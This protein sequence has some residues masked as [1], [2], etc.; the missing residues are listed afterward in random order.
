MN[1]TLGSITT[2]PGVVRGAVVPREVL[3]LTVLIDHDVVDGAVVARFFTRLNELVG[4]GC[5]L[6]V[7]P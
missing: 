2:K 7:Q 3:N 6:P 5:G 1:F 4:E